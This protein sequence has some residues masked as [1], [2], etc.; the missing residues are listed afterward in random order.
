[1]GDG[2][3]Q[4][5]SWPASEHLE[6]NQSPAGNL[7]S[8]GVKHFMCQPV[9]QLSHRSIAPVRRFTAVSWQTLQ[10]CSISRSAKA[11]FWNKSMLGLWHGAQF[12]TCSLMVFV[13]RPSRSKRPVPN[14]FLARRMILP[15]LGPSNL[16]VAGVDTPSLLPQSVSALA[17]T[18]QTACA[19]SA[20]CCG[21][22]QWP[23]C[24]KPSA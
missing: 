17:G 7:R 9:L 2:R 12:S 13:S 19:C 15:L 1:M 8:G 16:Q 22:V 18:P 23:S 5:T 10:T 20:V 6:Q 3:A 11:V 24:Q 14:T 4:V 21:A